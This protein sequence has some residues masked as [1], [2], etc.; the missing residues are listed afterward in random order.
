M[1]ATGRVWIAT[2]TRRE[3]PEDSPAW[4]KDVMVNVQSPAGSASNVP[5]A[6]NEGTHHRQLV[7]F[8]I[9]REQFSV[10]DTVYGTNHLQFDAR[11][12]LWTSGD[13]VGVGMFDPSAFD[14]QKSRET[15]AQAQ[16]VF[17]SINPETGTSVA[18][19]G[20]GIT[21]SPVDGTVWRTNTYIGQSGAADNNA[22]AGQNKIVK[23]DPKTLTFTDYPLPAPGRGAIG[24]DAASNGTIWFG[25]A[26]GHLG[27]FDPKTAKFRYWASPG[28]KLR[29][30]EQDSG[31]ADFHYSIFVD[32]FDAFGLGRDTVILTGANSDALVAFDPARERFTV[33]RVP[34][35]LGMYHRGV[36]GRIDDPKAGWKGRGLWLDYGGDP[37]SHV[38]TH[39]GYVC[40]IQL[41]PNPLAD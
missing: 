28:P 23:F 40:N 30:A 35:P 27:R 34:Y 9:N 11:G 16:K 36:D 38:E 10:I 39:I 26:S 19:G 2:Q 5:A 15:A 7:T 3:R 25:T 17:V 41:R 8:D 29:G 18:G 24:I 1:D 32:R 14:P 31:S 4:V 13:S 6:W 37:I 21:V 33:I 22:L 20:Y 12:R